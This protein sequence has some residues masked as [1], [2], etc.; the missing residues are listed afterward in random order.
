[1]M[2]RKIYIECDGGFGNRFNSLVTGLCI[3]RLFNLEPIVVWL[4]TN[5]CM[6]GFEEIF[7][8][9]VSN[10]EIIGESQFSDIKQTNT[11]QEMYHGF[12]Y[13]VDEVN[14]RPT[15]F[16]VLLKKDLNELYTLVSET[17][18]D[19][20]FAVSLIP[21]YF[22]L[23][24]ISSVLD[25]LVFIKEIRE[26][27]S[28]FLAKN[29]KQN[30]YGLH[31]RMTDFCTSE[32]QKQSWINLIKSNLNKDFFVC[33]DSQ[34]F[35]KEVSLF[36]NVFLFDKNSYVEKLTDGDWRHQFLDKDG[37]VMRFNVNRSSESVI[38]AMVDLLILSESEIVQTSHSTFLKTALLLRAKKRGLLKFGENYGHYFH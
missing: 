29:T 22:D 23:G 7:D 35:E 8:I 34:D 19:I 11:L 5:R 12:D 28:H 36:S 33:S 1:M 17:N 3:S 14:F 13:L 38:D 9:S 15:P 24:L 32:E 10:I 16:N 27:V 20:Y 4:Q 25:Q 31:M 26:K 2:R 21:K 6:A 18:N 37:R 30:F